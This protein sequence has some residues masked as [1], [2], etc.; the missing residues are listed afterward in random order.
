MP[1]CEFNYYKDAGVF[2]EDAPRGGGARGGGGR[3]G[4]GRGGGGRGDGGGYGGG[5]GGGGGGGGGGGPGQN[6][7]IGRQPRY[8]KNL[9]VGKEKVCRAYNNPGG[10]GNTRTNQGCKAKDGALFNHWCDTVVANTKNGVRLC[11]S[12]RHNHQACP[13]K[14]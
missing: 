11:G 9:A 5:A 13:K 1:P 4:G 3:G 10:C 14:S 2:G 12:I 7:E 8:N 6:E